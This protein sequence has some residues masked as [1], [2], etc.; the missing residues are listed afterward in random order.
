MSF[1]FLIYLTFHTVKHQGL[2]SFKFYARTSLDNDKIVRQKLTER[3]K[4]KKKG[5]VPSGLTIKGFERA[6]N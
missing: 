3:Q 6:K 4:E 5:N 2:K 1:F